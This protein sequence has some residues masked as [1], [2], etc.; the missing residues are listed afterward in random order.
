MVLGVI[1]G[2]F[3]TIFCNFFEKRDLVTICVSL[4]KIDILEVLSFGRR[5]QNDT[6]LQ[7]SKRKNGIGSC[8]LEF[9]IFG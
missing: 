5:I 9:S 4:G 3:S 7:N 6:N 8:R 1:L 2:D